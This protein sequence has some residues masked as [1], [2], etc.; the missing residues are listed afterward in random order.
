[1]YLISLRL[2]VLPCRRLFELQPRTKEV[3]GF[4]LHYNPKPSDMTH[5]IIHAIR[6][7]HMFDAAFNMVRSHSL[8]TA[9]SIS[10]PFTHI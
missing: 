3:F 7:F 8:K 6:M 4:D 10:M 1:L 9:L 5:I 2:V